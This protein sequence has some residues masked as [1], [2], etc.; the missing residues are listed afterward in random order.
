V[1]DDSDR[2]RLDLDRRTAELLRD[3]LHNVGE[4]QAAGAPIAPATREE[5]EKLG[6]LLRDLDTKLGGP[7]RFA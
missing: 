4:H 3:T 7:G 6:A 1:D 2:I 5:A